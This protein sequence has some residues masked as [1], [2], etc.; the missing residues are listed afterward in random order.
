[1]RG[2]HCLS[3]QPGSGL[4]REQETGQSFLPHSQEAGA[5]D[6]GEMPPLSGGPCSHSTGTQGT[7]PCRNGQAAPSGQE[8]VT[9]RCW[10]AALAKWKMQMVSPIRL[11]RRSVSGGS[12]TGPSW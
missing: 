6:D 8:A 5:R 7:G 11:E 1:M 3:Q 2:R 12:P 10:E 9:E 4:L